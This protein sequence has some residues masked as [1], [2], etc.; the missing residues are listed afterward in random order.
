MEQLVIVTNFWSQEFLLGTRFCDDS[1]R[2][3]QSRLN[4]FED[5]TSILLTPTTH[6]SKHS[7]WNL[8]YFLIATLINLGGAISKIQDATNRNTIWIPSHS[9][10]D[11]F[12]PAPSIPASLRTLGP[13]EPPK[14]SIQPSTYRIVQHVWNWEELSFFYPILPTD[15]AL[16]PEC[17]LTFLLFTIHYTPV[18]IHFNNN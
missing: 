4:G 17:L 6:L 14:T 9:T 2:C 5:G 3:W 12:D 15:L 8:E 13:L 10:T 7:P 16:R 11:F 1:A 18:T